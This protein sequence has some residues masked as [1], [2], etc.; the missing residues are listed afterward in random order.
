MS[1]ILHVDIAQR[2]ATYHKRDGAIVCGNKGYK[3]QFAFDGE[4]DAPA[5]KTARFIWNGEHT[6][7]K[8]T[9]DT[10]EVPV[11]TNTDKVMVGVFVEDLTTTTPAE[12]GCK[13][14]IRC[15]GTKPSEENER[16]YASEAQEAAAR[17]EAAAARAEAA[18]A[19]V[20]YDGTVTIE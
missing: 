11:I 5:E 13:R 14:S 1:K 7:V 6:D 16:K 18:A 20:E 15:S 12:I 10:C 17:A 3:I 2:I 8:F 4:W 9:G 19:A